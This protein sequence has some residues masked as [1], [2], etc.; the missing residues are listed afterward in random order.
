MLRSEEERKERRD[1]FG[2]EYRD[3]EQ[4]DGDDNDNEEEDEDEEEEDDY[5]DDIAEEEDEEDYE[6]ENE[7]ERPHHFG[8]TYNDTYGEGYDPIA[9]YDYG[10]EDD[11]NES[12]LPEDEQMESRG[13]SDSDEE[14]DGSDESESDD[15]QDKPY[16]Y[17]GEGDSEVQNNHAHL[18]SPLMYDDEA[19]VYR[20]YH[21]QE[22]D[23]VS[24]GS[25][26]D[27]PHQSAPPSTEP[28]RQD[29]HFSDESMT[30]MEG[31]QHFMDAVPEMKM[32][33]GFDYSDDS[34]HLFEY[35]T[36]HNIGNNGLHR[37][38][39]QMTSHDAGEGTSMVGYVSPLSHR[40]N[41]DDRGP[42]LNPT[43][44]STNDCQ[45]T[46]QQEQQ[47]PEHPPRVDN[48]E[49]A[50]QY[51]PDATTSQR[52]YQITFHLNTTDTTQVPGGASTTTSSTTTIGRTRPR[53]SFLAL[54]GP[55]STYW[56]RMKRGSSSTPSSS[57]PPY[58]P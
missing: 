26:H 44:S 25:F 37:Q 31:D 8:A 49:S 47:E 24:E 58:A 21:Y 28:R 36:N 11:S 41:N 30:N 7:N 40:P 46:H 19:S 1:R 9:N 17:D 18:L 45:H 38:A 27:H 10:Y 48:S 13:P 32:T 6:G 12:S 15:E 2:G 52:P 5:E 57:T 29:E 33:F 14:S 51:P 56:K 55:I 34:S 39:S 4:E 16:Y 3:Y 35:P 23:Q 43:F 22:E 50:P 42:E 53:S 54:P 20:D